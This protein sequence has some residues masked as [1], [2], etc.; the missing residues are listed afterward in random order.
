MPLIGILGGMGPL[1]TVDF[2]AKVVQLTDAACDQQHLPMLIANLPHVADRSRAI[3]GDG[4][5]CL[6]GLLDGIDLLNRNGV[7]L[8]TVPCNSA[9]HWYAQMRARSA[10][11]MLHIADAS[12][13]AV[14]ATARR[15]AVLGTGGTLVSGFYQAALAARDIEPLVPDADM[16]QR[17]AACIHAVK[18]GALERAAGELA[19][20]L[21]VLAAQGVRAAVM[22]CTEIPLAARLLPDPP[23][24]LIDSSLEL[25][26]AT[27]S[28]AVARGWNRPQ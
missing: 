25:A 5:D 13:A 24:T 7:G 2:M 16:Q 20:V 4:E 14:P 27:V 19:V 17:I 8:I 1:A 28:F 15:V 9:H 18:A 23:L 10:A 3:L 6:D 12:L 22:G 26:R 11:P 21:D